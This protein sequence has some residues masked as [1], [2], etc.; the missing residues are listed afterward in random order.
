ML[1]RQNDEGNPMMPSQFLGLPSKKEL[2]TKL[3]HEANQFFTDNDCGDVIDYL[4]ETFREGVLSM[5]K[6]QDHEDSE[7]VE[8]NAEVL[9]KQVAIHSSLCSFLSKSFDLRSKLSNPYNF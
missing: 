4:S 7:M 9:A 3:D 5:L 8:I 2:L 6:R 1:T